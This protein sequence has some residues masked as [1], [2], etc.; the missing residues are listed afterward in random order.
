MSEQHTNV[1]SGWAMLPLTIVTFLAV[2]AMFITAATI[3]ARAL[4]PIGIAFCVILGVLLILTAIF[5][6][7]GFFTLQPNQARVL[8]L[9][10]Q[11][12]GTVTSEGFHWTNPFQLSRGTMTVVETKPVWKNKYRVSLRSRNFE[13]ASLK[14]ND[15]RGNPIEIG[16][17]IVW[18]VRDTFK[19]IF[20]VDDYENYV[21]VQSESALRHLAS[22]HPYDHGDGDNE[23]GSVVTLRGGGEK[24]NACLAK[25][26]QERLSKAGVEVEEARLTHLAYAPEIAGAMLRR[27][28]AEAVIAARQKIVHGAVSMVEMALNELS[29]KQV[30]QLDE[31][32]KAAMVGNLLVVLCGEAE[33]Q[34]IVNAGTLYH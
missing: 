18:R 5:L 24:I 1:G 6:S 14:V 27:Q 22:S 12:K 16:A 20:E 31:E 21:L 26:T 3:G 23:D 19:A 10:G 29:A 34:P 17:V 25:E 33:A 15:Q 9:F 30:V 2:P 13:T 8:V 11:Y 7:T 28:Q 4:G 32:R